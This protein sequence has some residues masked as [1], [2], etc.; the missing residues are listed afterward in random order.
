MTEMK[1]NEYVLFFLNGLLHKSCEKMIYEGAFL[2]LKDLYWNGMKMDEI[3][4]E[5]NK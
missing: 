5:I 2:C 1:K 3:F 4:R